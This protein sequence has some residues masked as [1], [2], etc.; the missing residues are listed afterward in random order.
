MFNLEAEYAWRYTRFSGEWIRNHFESEMGPAV[1]RGYFLQAVQTLSPRLF[2]TVRLVGAS[3]PAY[4]SFGRERRS[5]TTAELSAGYRVHQ[6]LTLRGGYY[7]SRRF[8]AQER[9]HTAIA[10]V[11]WARRWF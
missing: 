11:V 4:T 3:S 6:E 8:G 2:A 1:A 10:S 5:M 7:S 9:E